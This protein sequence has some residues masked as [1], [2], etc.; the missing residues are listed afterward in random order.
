LTVFRQYKT[1]P[2]SNGNSIA[3]EISK[4]ISRLEKK[5][6]DVDWVVSNMWSIVCDTAAGVNHEV[7]V[8]FASV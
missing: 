7:V 2:S 6:P 5:F 1:L 8:E 4:E 3:N